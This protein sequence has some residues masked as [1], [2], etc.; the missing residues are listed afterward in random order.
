MIR[1]PNCKINLGLRIT[2]K[3]PDGFHNIESC[4]YPI[5]WNEAL[6][7]IP[8]PEL[9]FTSSGIP[10]PG[11]PDHNL[12]L[13]AWRL[14]H[15]RFD[16]AP[17]HIHLHKAIPI[18]AGLGGG[19]SDA[20]SAIIL[21]D[22]LF[23]LGLDDETME[24]L[25]RTLGSDCAFFIKNKP[26]IATEKGDRF[27]EVRLSLANQWIVLV[28]PDFHIS[29]GEAYSGVR[30]E[31]PED[32]LKNLLEGDV[33]EWKKYL[34]NDF[35]KHLFLNYPVLD[36]VKSRLYDFGS[37][38]ASMTGSGSCVYGLF[39]EEPDATALKEMGFTVKKILLN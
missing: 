4:F 39:N 15:K 1:F 27:S 2:E 26:V 32:S 36:H 8:A 17:V 19:S 35:E 6:E 22:Q 9:R 7:I 11:D 28:F 10:I 34:K 30:A 25:A 14:L 13:K 5:D 38:Y 16:I 18:G 29:T 37:F 23:D 24:D 12:C 21:L 31:K 20:A 3:R 33:K